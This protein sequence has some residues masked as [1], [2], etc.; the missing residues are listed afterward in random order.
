MRED[1]FRAWM[2][3][4]GNAPATISTRVSDARRIERH[5]G[6]LDE[7]YD[8]DRF[9]SIIEN[10]TYTAADRAAGRPN[11]SK[12]EIAGDLYANLGPYR[13]VLYV[14]ADFR[15][16]AVEGHSQADTIRQFVAD[17]FVE[18]ARLSG[19][20]SFSIRA[21]DV[22]KAMDL[23][24]LMPAVCSVLGGRKLL[25][26]A[27]ITLVSREGPMNGANAT[28]RYELVPEQPFGLAY[29]ESV[30]R[31]SYGA[32]IVDSQK[33]IAFSLSDGRQIALQRD[34]ARVQLW[35]EAG[36]QDD[37]AVAQFL[38]YA[39]LQG[40]HSNLP[41]RLRHDSQDG[42]APRAVISA[43]AQDAT[44]LR[45]LLNWYEDGSNRGDTADPSQPSQKN[46]GAIT[47]R[48]TNLILYGPPGTGKTY[49]TAYE[50]V[51]LCDGSA[52]SDRAELKRRYDSLFEAGQISF[53]TFHQSYSYEDF[54]EGLRP[55]TGTAETE[56]ESSAAGFRLEP[57]RGIFREIASLAEQAR[58]TANQPR[59]FDLAGRNFIKM[60]L[61]RVGLEDHIY[62]A[63]IEGNYV[64]LGWG[65]EVDWSE[66]NY[67]D[68]QAIFDR[69][70]QIEPGTNGNSGNISQ[71][72]RFRN[73]MKEGDIIIVSSGNSHF[74]A[75]AEIVGP[76][77]YEPTGERTYNHRREVKW[78]L[79][80]DD[81][82][83]IE[84]IYDG[85][86][87]MQSCYGLKEAKIKKEALSRLLPGDG[88]VENSKPDQF[89]LIIDEINRANISKVFGELITLLEHDK[90]VGADNALRL[91]LPYSGE[92]FGVPINLHV[93]GTMNTA[94]RSIA[95]LD[96]ALR[97]RFD[98]RELM[99]EPNL[100][101]ENVGGVPL[102]NMLR[103]LNERIEYL[104][105]RE[106]QIGHAYFI[107]CTSKAQ[108]DATMR[109]RVIPLLQE[110]FYEDWTKV[111][112][113][114][115]DAD[116]AGRFIERKQLGALGMASSDA[117]GD[118]RYRWS[119]KPAFDLSAYDQFR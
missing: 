110:Y 90:R 33:M 20:A 71:V 41:D 54:V 109:D 96:T 72:W 80:L 2:E 22:H 34:V 29:V 107:G 31:Q 60:S 38:R 65:G 49:A 84:T 45:E 69:W 5:Y 51:R 13:S 26:A 81:P 36:E 113:V 108:I 23:A 19:D 78:L 62:E 28:F 6:D 25:R 79:V 42:V 47:V 11:P 94:D 32:P 52:P 44:E 63:A 114:V 116:G 43:R 70:N 100:L 61:G 8:R 98:F 85:V 58:K 9:A 73:G 48:P 77:R 92:M 40:R 64:V 14:Y 83:P 118:L 117:P 67:N 112:L 103:L 56:D 37:P 55:T 7:L 35:F 17:N 88:P 27:G 68:H 95:L 93:V 91:K 99:P 12:L 119:V 115:G 82:L 86:L 46:V 66:P 59:G 15:G 111:A 74:R 39:P 101:E 30:L 57:R 87:T 18:P 1:D 75:I 24:N 105:D 21:G 97:R 4:Q 104:F 102:R 16:G 3:A 10:L 53:V 50:A 106:H 89:V 76:Y